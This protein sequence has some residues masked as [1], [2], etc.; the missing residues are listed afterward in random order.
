MGKFG[1]RLVE[2]VGFRNRVYMILFK[3]FF[4]VFIVVFFSVVYSGWMSLIGNGS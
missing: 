2:M 3:K 4:L 1:P